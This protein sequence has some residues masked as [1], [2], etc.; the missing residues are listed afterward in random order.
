MKI[1]SQSLMITLMTLDWIGKYTWAIIENL[2]GITHV[3][4]LEIKI[5]AAQFPDRLSPMVVLVLIR[6]REL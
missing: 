4:F 5:K 3:R 2:E 1:C 6:K